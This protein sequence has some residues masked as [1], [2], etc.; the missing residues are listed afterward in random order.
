MYCNLIMSKSYKRTRRNYSMRQKIKILKDLNE[1]KYDTATF[2]R[3]INIPVRTLQNWNA[4]RK[5]IL[6]TNKKDINKKKLGSGNKPILNYDV[7]MKILNWFFDVRTRGIPITD[8]LIKNRAL[9][10][11]KN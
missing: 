11:K 4:N 1:S 3:K 6:A 8:I 5:K 2:A 10:L 9:F 7:E